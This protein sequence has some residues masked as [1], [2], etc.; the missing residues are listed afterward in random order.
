MP[1]SSVPVNTRLTLFSKPSHRIV[2]V[3]LGNTGLSCVRHLQRLGQKVVVMDDRMSP[4]CLARCQQWFPDVEIVLGGYDEKVLCAADGIVVSPGVSEQHPCFIRPQGLDIP[5]VGDVEL[6]MQVVQK[7]VVLVTGSNGKSTVVTLIGQMM[8]QAGY[9]V[10]VGGN[11]GIPVLDL[12]YTTDNV[13]YFVLELSSYQL[14]RSQS[15]HAEIAVLLNISTD[16][17]DWHGNFQAYVDAKQQVF[18]HCR[19]AIYNRSAAEYL[20]GLS[21]DHV[22]TFGMDAPLDDQ[23][24]VSDLSDGQAICLGRKTLMPTRDIMRAWPHEI[25]NAM[26]VC[27][28]ARC[29]GI[30]QDVVSKTL[31]RFDGLP[32]RCQYV[33]KC[34]GVVWYNDS[35]ATNVASAVAAIIAISGS[36]SGRLWVIL[37][38][39]HKVGDDYPLL[40]RVLSQHAKGVVLFG[41]DRY[42]LVQLMGQVMP[43]YQVELT[44]DQAV[45]YVKEQVVDKDAV[46]MSPA[47]SSFDQFDHFVHRGEHF[48]QLVTQ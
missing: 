10:A 20:K 23:L 3:G 43:A 22:M 6:F 24:G 26:A 13:D 12:L 33:A 29:L 7:P 15:Q 31:S 38:G 32:H 35:K 18:K 44:L 45:A 37:G 36:V 16:H 8:Q 21:F 9:R 2:V 40:A 1:L 5:I 46:L 48:I 34:K 28:V 41:Q 42:H 47:C 4:P 27:A 19:Y 17:I 25:E 30:E 14:A 39:I 11:I